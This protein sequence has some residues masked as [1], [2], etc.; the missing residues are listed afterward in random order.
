M[1]QSENTYPSKRQNLYLILCLFFVTNAIVAEVLG[2]KIFSLDKL[3]GH[4]LSSGWMQFNLS[5]G[6]IIWPVV[7]LTTDIINQF[8]GK[9][10]VVKISMI[11]F[12]LL[13]FVFAAFFMGTKL[14]PA[15]FWLTQN[16]KDAEGNSFNPN[17]AFSFFLLQGMNIIIGSLTAFLTSQLVDALVYHS[18]RRLTQEKYIWIRATGSTIISQF[19]DSFL[20]LF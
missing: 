6:V 16:N 1:Q 9:R 17:A 8:Y 19:I 20:I 13:I 7:F 2:P 18:I 4:S 11:T 15:D 10:G 12:C 14:P 3:V 5:S